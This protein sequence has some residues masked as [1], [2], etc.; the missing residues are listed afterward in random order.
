MG[1]GQEHDEEVDQLL[2][3]GGASKSKFLKVDGQKTPAR[4]DPNKGTQMLRLALAVELPLVPHAAAPAGL[5]ADWQSTPALGVSAAPAL[6]W[7]V[8]ACDICSPSA[9]RTPARRTPAHRVLLQM[10]RRRALGWIA[11]ACGGQ[12]DATQTVSLYDSTFS[13]TVWRLYG[14][15]KGL[16]MWQK[17]AT[18][19]AHA[20]AGRSDGDEAKAGATPVWDSG[21]AAGNASVAVKCG[22]PALKG[23]AA[24]HWTAKAR[25]GSC[26]S[27]TSAPVLCPRPPGA[28]KRP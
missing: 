4:A 8:P 24:Y 19:T 7:I 5:L 26:A 25:A 9:R 2:A 27:E 17:D 15:A 18:Q 11:P 28:V 21:K 22:G 20:I 14:G 1:L 13:R 16:V 3:A 23:G 6:G 12:K 10:S